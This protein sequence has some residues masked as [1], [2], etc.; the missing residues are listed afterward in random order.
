[1]LENQVKCIER[2]RRSPSDV[3][4]RACRFGKQK[5]CLLII[6]PKKLQIAIAAASIPVTLSMRLQKLLGDWS[7]LLCCCFLHFHRKSPIPLKKKCSNVRNRN[8][9]I[10]QML[11]TPQ[12]LS[13]KTDTLLDCFPIR[14]APV[15]PSFKVR[16]LERD[17]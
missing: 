6:I 4:F 16:L 11:S 17:L 2:K 9:K 7:R 8:R 14:A 12:N 13:G 3:A 15:H 1:V 5:T 10:I